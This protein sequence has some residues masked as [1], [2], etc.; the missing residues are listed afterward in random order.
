[1]IK[2]DRNALKDAVLYAFNKAMKEVGYST[3]D[4]K[5]VKILLDK[6]SW[7]AVYPKLIVKMDGNM[8][9]VGKSSKPSAEVMLYEFFVPSDSKVVFNKYMFEDDVH[10]LVEKL[11]KDFV[12]N[13]RIETVNEIESRISTVEK[14]YDCNLS[15]NVL[16]NNS[17]FPF[18]VSFSIKDITIDGIHFSPRTRE[19]A[20]IDGETILGNGP[21]F[22]AFQ[23]SSE[24]KINSP[25]DVEN[26]NSKVENW[27]DNAI[28]NIRKVVSTIK[29]RVK[30]IHAN[31]QLFEE[32]CDKIEK[33]LEKRG[34]RNPSVTY[35]PFFNP[36]DSVVE[37]EIN[38]A[39][40][41]KAKYRIESEDDLKSEMDKIYN[42]A[43]FSSN[44]F[45]KDPA[46]DLSDIML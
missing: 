28:N 22:V 12:N 14:K 8:S 35:K 9:Y 36:E 30:L 19:V 24:S 20:T 27:L 41:F 34:L 2:I 25:A 43:R 26:I 38:S 17:K 6:A 32:G 13:S 23:T 46:E 44:R 37:I 39:N 15:M 33:M 31:E 4:I 10:D 5:P 21:I 11:E 45:V 16:P 42:K 7:G 3:D 1:M 18:Q 29:K 40:G